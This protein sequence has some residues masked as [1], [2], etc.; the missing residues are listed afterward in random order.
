MLGTSAIARLP[1]V[2][3]RGGAMEVQWRCNGGAMER[4]MLSHTPRADEGGGGDGGGGTFGG[5]G[6]CTEEYT[7][8]GGTR[9]VGNNADFRLQSLHDPG[10]Q[11]TELNMKLSHSGI[12]VQ[13]GARCNRTTLHTK[14][15][16]AIQYI[17]TRIIF[18]TQ[19]L[20]FLTHQNLRRA[21]FYPLFFYHQ[22]IRGSCFLKIHFRAFDGRD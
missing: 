19:K 7:Q 3:E 21:I 4:Y 22:N 17:P 16:T 11:L 1:S 18:N 10:P 5:G 20:P 15:E 13:Q 6:G 14:I 12:P 9:G 2:C 8:L